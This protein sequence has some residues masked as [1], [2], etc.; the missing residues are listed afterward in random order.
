[1]T[2]EELRERVRRVL[3]EESHYICEYGDCES[4]TDAILAAFDETTSECVTAANE[5]ADALGE[6]AD[7]NATEREMQ[8]MRAEAAEA[9][10]AEVEAGAAGMRELLARVKRLEAIEQAA[11]AYV[12]A[13]MDDNAQLATLVSAVEAAQ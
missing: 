12:N 6:L 7:D 3:R 4:A 10:L 5:R 9:R 11:T 2:R 8:A 1:M 13:G